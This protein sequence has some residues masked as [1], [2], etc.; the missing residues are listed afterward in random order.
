MWLVLTKRGAEN[1]GQD[2]KQDSRPSL[3]RHDAAMGPVPGRGWFY[4]AGR[5]PRA[6][7]TR[8]VLSGPLQKPAPDTR[9]PGHGLGIVLVWPRMSLNEGRGSGEE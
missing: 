9:L 5:V 4:R 7:R 6:N 3:D 2:Q 1:P 8:Y